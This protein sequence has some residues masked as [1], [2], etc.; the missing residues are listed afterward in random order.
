MTLCND[1]L[2]ALLAE[3]N[4][5]VFVHPSGV[6]DAHR[7]RDFYLPQLVGYPAET[8]LSI[9]RMIY[10]RVFERFDL[11]MCLAHGGGCLPWLRGRL[12]LGWQRKDVAHTTKLPPSQFCKR[13]YYDTAVFDTSLLSHLVSDMGADRILLGTDHPFELG[14]TDPVATVLS[15]GLGADGHRGDPLAHS[16]FPARVSVLGATRG[17]FREAS[18]VTA[19]DGLLFARLQFGLTTLYHFFFVPVSISLAL[20]LAIMQ[21]AWYR[22]GKPKYLKMVKFWSKPFLI[23]F[24]VGVVTGIVL[25]FEFGMNWSEYSRFVGDV[26]GAPLAME[27]LLAFFLEATFIGLWIFGWD[28]LPKGLHLV[29]IWCVAIGTNLSAYFILD[30]KL[31]DA[32]SRRVHLQ[33]GIRAERELTDIWAVLTN[34]VA[35]VAYPHILIGRIARGRGR[36]HRDRGVAPGAASAHRGHARFAAVRLVHGSGGRHRHHH[37]RR[38]AGQG[39]D[40]SSADE[41]GGGGS[42]LGLEVGRV[43][44]AL[45]HRNPRRESGKSSPSASRTCF[46]IL[47]TATFTRK[48][49]AS[50][51][52]RPSTSSGSGPATTRRMSRR[53]T[54]ASGT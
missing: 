7:Q 1:D 12:D 37:H 35:V 36:H 11:Y 51:T 47:P 41:D 32:E 50:T 10:G 3:R 40:R 9:A 53:P 26:F 30:G 38:H 15:L 6:P 16:G 19:M 44:L 54:G 49:R 46:P 2:W 21:T 14:D 34:P 48:S 13:L 27:A 5:F 28:R 39:D 45:H 24:A 29:C 43:V 18:P 23:C 31:V 25:E 8:A 20:Y 4:V 22:T 52:C 17:P 42:P 33:R